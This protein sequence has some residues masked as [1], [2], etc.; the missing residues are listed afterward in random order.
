M[1]DKPILFVAGF[2]RCGTTMMM[3]M[4]DRGGF[5]VVGPR[6]AYEVGEMSP[7]A[8]PDPQWLR[9][10]AGKAVKWIDPIKARIS[11]NDLPTAPVIIHMD[12]DKRNMAASQVKMVST[13]FPVAA[14]NDR[15]TR[16]LFERSLS[17]DAPTLHGYL[18]ATGMVYSFTFEWVLR[19][20]LAAAQKLAAIIDHEF[21]RG[22][23]V[24]AAAAVPL[25]RSPECAA[26][27]SIELSMQP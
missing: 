3:T 10:C 5:P 17:A 12:R 1:T 15:R 25:P 7:M 14:T 24:A 20:P 26:D 9:A 23:D 16:R 27:I 2:G 11:R 18:C 8:K 6:P 4:L 13:F 21:D 19:E 22:F